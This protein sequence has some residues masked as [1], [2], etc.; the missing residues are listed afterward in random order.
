LVTVSVALKV[1]QV[2]IKGLFRLVQ[3]LELKPEL[4]CN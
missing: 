4:F 2:A 1:A 3:L